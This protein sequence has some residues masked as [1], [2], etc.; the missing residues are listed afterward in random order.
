MAQTPAFDL[1]RMSNA[2][3]ILLGGGVLL[4]IDSFLMWQ[5]DCESLPG[6]EE[7]CTDEHSMWDG[8]GT[9]FGLLAGLLVIAL[10]VWE[11]L[12]LAKV[13]VDIGVAIDTS[14]IGALLGFGVLAMVLLKFVFVVTNAALGAW[15]GLFLALAIGYGAWMR[16]QE[17]VA[18]VPPPPTTNGGMP[19]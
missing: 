12:H 19:S 4:V 6:V 13:V 9:V 11:A 2:S 5:R 17:P 8:A 7:I 3:K 14:K 18:A 15:M 16:L 1:S 10:I